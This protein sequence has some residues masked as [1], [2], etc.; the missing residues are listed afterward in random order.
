MKKTLLAAVLCVSTGLASAAA[1]TS[2]EVT[3]GTFALGVPTATDPLNPAAFA[4]MSVDG[5]Y[6]GSIPSSIGTSE[7]DYVP[8][9]IVTFNFSIFGPVGVFTQQTDS[10]G[11]GPF[12]GVTGDLTGNALTLDMRSWTA[13]WNG[14]DFNQGAAGVTATT[15]ASGNFNTTWSAV[16][17]GGAFDGQIGYWSLNGVAKAESTPPPEVPVPAAAW[18]MGSGL[19]GLVGVARRRRKAS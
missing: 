14:T 15:D 6:D 16:V 19:L 7:S 2:L 11:N 10:V 9:S 13:F 18:L 17:V 5:S 1:I 12:P 4:N 8:T 3:G